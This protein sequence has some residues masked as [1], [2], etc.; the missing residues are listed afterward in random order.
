M[1]FIQYLCNTPSCFPPI[2]CF[3]GMRYIQS[4]FCVYYQASKYDVGQTFRRVVGTF[5]HCTVQKPFQANHLI[6]KRR[7]SQESHK[8]LNGSK[9]IEMLTA[10][11]WQ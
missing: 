4:F 10:G 1:L 3:S 2:Y 5:K 7:E 9:E 11:L 6:K 8:P